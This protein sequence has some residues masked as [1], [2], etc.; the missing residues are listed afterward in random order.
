MNDGAER[1]ADP[2]RAPLDARWAAYLATCRRA[3]DHDHWLETTLAS[4]R[5]E[6]VHYGAQLLND[7]T[8]QPWNA[9]VAQRAFEDYR[10]EAQRYDAGPA[11]WEAAFWGRLRDQ[12]PELYSRVD[13]SQR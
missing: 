12:A 4:Y 11:K 3:D 6:I 9:A 1:G 7:C 2:F 13:A 8:S 10:A 5:D